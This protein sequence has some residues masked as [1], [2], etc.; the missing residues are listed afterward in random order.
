[1]TI[2]TIGKS[3]KAAP[4]AFEFNARLTGIPYTA[5]AIIKAAASE[6]REAQC[7]ATRKPASN[8]KST[9]MGITA[10]SVESIRLSAT[11]V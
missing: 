1:M 10:T 5:T 2:Q 7:A 8:T 9:A 3:P 11:G 4:A 6:A